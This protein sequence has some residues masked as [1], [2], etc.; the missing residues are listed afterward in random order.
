[1]VRILADDGRGG[2]R[3]RRWG[4]AR[5]I[6]A[7]TYCTGPRTL[8]VG[9]LQGRRVWRHGGSEA[10]CSSQ[11]KT[12]QRSRAF[13]M[14]MAGASTAP[15]P[16]CDAALVCSGRARSQSLPEAFFGPMSPRRPNYSPRC[17]PPLSCPRPPRRAV[18]PIPR[19]LGR[20]LA[21]SCFRRVSK[22]C[23]LPPWRV[24]R[25]CPGPQNIRSDLQVATNTTLVGHGPSPRE[26]PPPPAAA[27]APARLHRHPLCM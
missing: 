10:R 2:S 4:R 27:Q 21:W 23:C 7:P 9:G 19:P 1:M 26:S 18:L 8:A 6:A 12:R 14:R 25:V 11:R 13:R 22:P 20:P 17:P 5:Y 16:G 24:L 3:R 15:G